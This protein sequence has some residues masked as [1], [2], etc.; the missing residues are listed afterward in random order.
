MSDFPLLLAERFTTLRET[1]GIVE[2]SSTLGLATRGASLF[3]S[4]NGKGVCSR[5]SYFSHFP[6]FSTTRSGQIKFSQ[7]PREIEPPCARKWRRREVH[8]IAPCTFTV[9][10]SIRG[11]RALYRGH[12]RRC[13]RRDLATKRALRLIKLLKLGHYFSARGTHSISVSR[14][15]APVSE[16]SVEDRRQQY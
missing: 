3:A 10:R 14:S 1:L 2:I 13:G 4:A 6:M 16:N 7:F 8:C 11:E 9:K 15:S 12:R 5:N